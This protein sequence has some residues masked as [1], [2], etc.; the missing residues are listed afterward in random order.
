MTTQHR[1]TLT[2]ALIALAAALLIPQV[3]VSDD[4]GVRDRCNAR[5]EGGFDAYRQSTPDDGDAYETP[6]VNITANFTK[7]L[8]AENIN[9]TVRSENTNSY[10]M[11]VVSTGEATSHRVKTTNPLPDGTYYVNA[12]GRDAA[13]NR[14]KCVEFTVD[15]GS[16]DIWVEEPSPTDVNRP[17]FAF[18]DDQPSFDLTVRTSQPALCRIGPR[19]ADPDS[20]K[21]AKPFDDEEDESYE[22]T[23]EDF[24]P[25]FLSFEANTTR[26]ATI[27]C[28]K[29]T[30]DTIT[31]QTIQTGYYDGISFNQDWEPSL[32]RTDQDRTTNLTVN[33]DQRVL[34]SISPDPDSITYSPKPWSSPIEHVDFSDDHEI[35]AE[36]PFS[37]ATYEFETSCWNRA[38]QTINETATLETRN[39]DFSVSIEEPSRVVNDKT[40]DVNITANTEAFSRP[41]GGCE[42]TI[43]PGY[44]D[45]VTLSL[46]GHVGDGE[47]AWSAA[48]VELPQEETDYQIEAECSLG[49]RTAS[50]STN[51][52]YSEEALVIETPEEKETS[53]KEFRVNVSSSFDDLTECSVNQTNLRTGESSEEP[54]GNRHSPGDKTYYW[55]DT[56]YDHGE[57]RYNVSV[58]CG[59]T[60]RTPSVTTTYIESLE[61][62]KPA[63]TNTVTPEIDVEAGINAK[64]LQGCEAIANHPDTTVTKD[65]TSPDDHP[66]TYNT[67]IDLPEDTTGHYNISAVCELDDGQINTSKEVYYNHTLL[68]KE[69]PTFKITQD[70]S[71][72]VNVSTPRQ[73]LTCT[74][75]PTQPQGSEPIELT[76]RTAADKDYHHGEVNL[77]TTGDHTILVS[78]ENQ[79]TGFQD[80]IEFNIT[81]ADPLRFTD[82]TPKGTNTSPVTI[83]VNN[84]A[85]NLDGCEAE[86]HQIGGDAS[87]TTD[88]IK[89]STNPAVYEGSMKLPAIGTYEINA[90]C[91]QTGEATQNLHYYNNLF[92]FAS[93]TKPVTDDETV[94]VEIDENPD[95]LRCTVTNQNTQEENTIG[96]D[97]NKT[98]LPLKSGV[99]DLSATCTAG[100]G[101]ETTRETT[102]H[103]STGF[104]FKEPSQPG[105]TEDTF[106]VVINSS[107]DQLTRCQVDAEGRTTGATNTTDLTLKKAK[108]KETTYNG[109]LTISQPDRYDLTA[110]CDNVGDTTTS[111]AYYPGATDIWVDEP[112][113][114]EDDKPTY[115]FA[116]VKPSEANP[117]PISL[118]TERPARCKLAPATQYAVQNYE[119]AYNDF[120]ETLTDS[121]N[122]SHSY[123]WVPS[124]AAPADGTNF[125]AICYEPDNPSLSGEQAYAYQELT[126][127]W[128][129]ERP[130]ATVTLEPSRLAD[131]SQPRSTLFIDANDQAVQCRVSSDPTNPIQTI[132][133]VVSDDYTTN[134]E[135]TVEARP[136]LDYTETV[137]NASCWNRAR[138]R[139]QNTTTL[140]INYTRD[141]GLRIKHPSTDVAIDENLQVEARTLR[142]EQGATCNATIGST[143]QTLSHQGQAQN[144]EHKYTGTISLTETGDKSLTVTCYDLAPRDVTAQHTF[145]FDPDG[146]QI[147]K[148]ADEYVTDEPITIQGRST[149]TDLTGCKA[150]VSK[151]TGSDVTQTSLSDKSEGEHYYQGQA[152]LDHGPGAY[153]VTAYC[154][155]TPAVTKTI[156]YADNVELISPS[157]GMKT[158]DAEITA[159]A[160]SPVGGVSCTFTANTSHRV[161]DIVDERNDGQTVYK[162][163]MTFDAEGTHRVQARCL[164]GALTDNAT[165]VY[166]ESALEYE[167]PSFD[168]TNEDEVDV[169][170]STKLDGLT[171]TAKTEAQ[172]PIELTSHEAGD[173]TYHT[174]TVEIPSATGHH[175]ITTSCTDQDAYQ[176]NITTSVHRVG[177]PEITKPDVATQANPA[178]IRI[179]SPTDKLTCDAEIDGEGFTGE[180]VPPT[181]KRLSYDAK[182]DGKHVYTNTT[183]FPE[184]GRYDIAVSCEE[185]T[186]AKTT[187]IS[188]IPGSTPIWVDEPGHPHHD[189]PRFAAT[190]KSELPLTIDL[191]TTRPATCKAQ[192]YQPPQGDDLPAAYQELPKELSTEPSET[193]SYEWQP[194]SATKP[195]STLPLHV[196]CNDTSN[197]VI[198]DENS[199]TYQV[200]NL[201]YY[202]GDLGAPDVNT[203]PIRDKRN[204]SSTITTTTT[205]RPVHC[206]YQPKTT[207]THIESYTPNPNDGP[208][209]YN[210]YKKRTQTTLTIDEDHEANIPLTATCTDL[211]GD[212]QTTQTT[213]DV[214]YA[215]DTQLTIQKPSRR[216]T[217][218]QTFPVEVSTPTQPL[219]ADPQCTATLRYNGE[220]TTDQTL[221]TQGLRDDG[222][223][224]YNATIG[225]D[226]Q[227]EHTLNVSCNG[228]GPDPITTSKQILHDDQILQFETPQDELITTPSTH[229]VVSS[230]DAG[231]EACKANITQPNGE[232]DTYPLTNTT[233]DGGKT[234]YA[235]SDPVSID[236]N[237]DHTLRASCKNTIHTPS[238]TIHHTETFDLTEPQHD[239]TNDENI[240]LEATTTTPRPTCK[241]NIT[242]LDTQ[243]NNTLTLEPHEKD[244]GLVHYNTTHTLPSQATYSIK[245]YCPDHPV[246]QDQTTITYDESALEYE[247][248]GFDVTDQTTV[249]INVSTRLDG[250]TCTATTEAQDPTTLTNHTGTTKNYHTGT[251]EIPSATGHH[252]ITTS[253]TDQDAYQANITTDVYR[254][255][256]LDIVKPDTTVTEDP[257]VTIKADHDINT[258]SCYATYTGTTTEGNTVQG[259][260]RAYLT[261]GDTYTG[262]TTLPE[263]GDYTITLSCDEFTDTTSS[264]HITY[265]PSDNAIWIEEPKPNRTTRPNYAQATTPVFDL[266]L[267]TNKDMTCKIARSATDTPGLPGDQTRQEAYQ[268]TDFTQLSGGPTS[269]TTTINLEGFPHDQPV[270]Y[271]TVCQRG[272]TYHYQNLYLSHDDTPPTITGFSASPAT[273]ISTDARAT[274][275]TTSTEDDR[276]VCEI[277]PATTSDS[278]ED[279]TDQPWQAPIPQQ[280]YTDEQTVQS[281]LSPNIDDT[282][283]QFNAT[284]MDPTGKTDT[285]QTTVT[286]DYQDTPDISIQAP[287]ITNNA[288]PSINITSPTDK[289]TNC[290]AQIQANDTIGTLSFNEPVR[291][292][293]TF[294]YTRSNTVNLPSE[295][296]YDVNATCQY[297]QLERTA[298]TE[299]AYDTTPPTTPNITA[300]ENVCGDELTVTI[301]ADDNTDTIT[302]KAANASNESQVYEESNTDEDTYT[303]TTD[304]GSLPVNHTV[305]L[306]AKATD[307]AGNTATRAQQITKRDEGSTLCDYED[308]T[309]SLERTSSDPVTYNVSCDDNNACK[310]T[311]KYSM[312]PHPGQCSYDKENGLGNK[313][314]VNQNGYLCVAV[315]DQNNN[316]DTTTRA[317][318]ENTVPHCEDNEKNYEETGVDCGGPQSECSLCGK[319]QSC[320]TDTDCYTDLACTDGQCQEPA[321]HCSNDELDEDKGETDVDCGGPCD[322]CSEDNATCAA[323]TDCSSNNC[324]DN[325]C[326][327]A[328][329]NDGIQNQLEQAVDCGGPN[330]QACQTQSGDT[331]DTDADCPGTQFKCEQRGPQKI[332]VE[333]IQQCSNDVQDGE[334]TGVD[335]G[336]PDCAACT[337][338]KS[339]Q[340]NSDCISGVCQ[341][342][343]CQTPSCSDGIKNQGEADIDCGTVCSNGNLCGIGDQCTG[344]ADCATGNCDSDAGLCAEPSCTNNKQDGDETDVDCG[345]SLCR[346]QGKLCGNGDRCEQGGD[347]QTDY[348]AD[349]GTCKIPPEQDSDNDGLPDRWE[350]KHGAG[351]TSMEPFQDPDDDGF[352]NLEEY[353]EG[354][355]PFDSAS[356]PKRGDGSTTAIV[357]LITG[358]LFAATGGALIY[359]DEPQPQKNTADDFSLDDQPS[360][361]T[362]D[363]PR[364]RPDQPQ[365]PSQPQQ[366]QKRPDTMDELK[367]ERDELLSPFEET[368]DDTTNDTSPQAPPHPDETGEEDEYTSIDE[369]TDDDEY[370]EDDVFDKL[371]D[372]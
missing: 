252:D 106:E 294:T 251:V 300:K 69:E 13:Y 358:T 211:T 346:Q 293:N 272:D 318:D 7:E 261:A 12:T 335:C 47:Y 207:E 157:Q 243:K 319:G 72:P 92:T 367:E 273:L 170:V 247:E 56:E 97:E 235:T 275:L 153:N 10:D 131:S 208:D 232:T 22:H 184:P 67:T 24:P 145:T 151:R 199:Y 127:G 224:Y 192:E 280:A 342:N 49:E 167:Q 371:D 308:P 326:Q 152:T 203:V 310:E 119:E 29:P 63:T 111:Y 62:T 6:M 190:T 316:N 161:G 324:V 117:L 244:N 219:S 372:L 41:E 148:P 277:Q 295:T 325:Q 340:A 369:T 328:T 96:S 278:I 143:E 159:E 336:G 297:R 43:Q 144:G 282:D 188:Y 57:G 186:G 4:Q 52:F 288:T 79:T 102:V 191:A 107:T 109:S 265:L 93:P 327:P 16:L 71:I 315:Y 268:S 299:I 283:V 17:T 228:Y 168:V 124:D 339:C 353:N 114:P 84:T 260:Q 343:T 266:T 245:A 285:A 37:A 19:G 156:K 267:A 80:S 134:H 179:T 258:L 46:D 150:N 122:T 209:G 77:P 100:N 263:H 289:L 25:G 225:F 312:A 31:A 206:T 356:K 81:K 50:D 205:D 128:T 246:L 116:E 120:P 271:D 200:I 180:A 303:T 198:D 248:P 313:I 68:T 147:T 197:P 279:Y 264:T 237:G 139:V 274:T 344:D 113:H 61:L 231:R 223:Y 33:S 345:G 177:L 364:Q 176:A 101:Y 234:L 171:C 15:A 64:S 185:L 259:D 218:D 302:Y 242:N 330:C 331:C 354:T 73:G 338:G 195:G 60:E 18:G 108:D 215:D 76:T 309:I 14:S 85:S 149:I 140:E 118:A 182:T 253:C 366:E 45:P 226:N 333:T 286:V 334:E 321:D 58:E 125:H 254:A 301:D 204:P 233:Q 138:Q 236:E 59:K 20:F 75:T 230:Y 132:E 210:D 110:S 104:T 183:T 155:E 250:L 1:R 229:I 276:V 34:C 189:R 341:N 222:R 78:C 202:E 21:Q 99:N 2:W 11:Q 349:D 91:Q 95:G 28:Q 257:N 355:D 32:L 55:E 322:G 162:T 86:A 193:H 172:D 216:A 112:D 290:Q 9:I 287:S 154:P 194:S 53:T 359:L 136:G 311:Y 363:Q 51:V 44:D 240:I 332:C 26:E 238:T 174:G 82:P 175:D 126:F 164:N 213:V 135:V 5:F 292:G 296:T 166:D 94:T 38:G 158:N 255:G 165:V 146:L 304:I 323:D 103:R 291:R 23:M 220:T 65:L 212:N 27:L 8:A 370:D 130:T 241:A 90:S 360:P 133:P 129:T 87:N 352:T 142:H 187:N 169:N 35:R 88:L 298:N 368:P 160:Q 74:A 42:A 173:A 269:H 284:C 337:T 305:L 365:T 40:I 347:C 83:A 141:V 48:D 281:T 54:I 123:D 317:V 178:Q 314:N 249:G 30:D 256:P 270:L 357:M 98:T 217:N 201:T 115:A 306:Q 121:A 39:D 320:E 227:G 105:G 361:T 70:D 329:C 348:C 137:I 307:K 351:K 181:T 214:D 66:Y 89:R 163:N 3:A 36:L 239:K 350:N 362:Q 196:I 221:F 262:E